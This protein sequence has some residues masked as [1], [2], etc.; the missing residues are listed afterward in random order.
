MKLNQKGVTL[1]E[2]I[3]SFA[4]VAV[5]IIYFYQT[6]YTV[7]NL[8]SKAQRETDEFVDVNYAYR[9]ID[10]LYNKYGASDVCTNVIN[11]NDD[12]FKVDSCNADEK[13]NG[14][15]VI[16]F[17]V[18]EKPYKLYYY[19]GVTEPYYGLTEEIAVETIKNSLNEALK[20]SRINGTELEEYVINN[21]GIGMFE[22][23]NV[24]DETVRE[25]W[26]MNSQEDYDKIQKCSAGMSEQWCNESSGGT[27]LPQRIQQVVGNVRDDKYCIFKIK[28]SFYLFT[29]DH[30][31]NIYKGPIIYI[32]SNNN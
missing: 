6:L 21:S 13:T 1:V 11:Y 22:T 29:T 4:L 12:F 15:R 9:I 14:F 10:A 5:A 7:K 27:L 3:V 31:N 23:F 2:L 18:N 32:D 20:D 30:S 26:C 8:Y 25:A 17:N 16:S 19:E 28:G 24:D